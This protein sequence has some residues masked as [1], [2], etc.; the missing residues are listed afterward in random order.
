MAHARDDQAAQEILFSGSWASAPSAA[1]FKRIFFATL[2]PS[3]P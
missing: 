1:A 3:R 2:A